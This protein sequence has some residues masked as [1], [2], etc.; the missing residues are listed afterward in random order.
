[1]SDHVAT[2]CSRLTAHATLSKEM[3]A[4]GFVPDAAVCGVVITDKQSVVATRHS[5]GRFG[6]V[7]DESPVPVTEPVVSGIGLSKYYDRME[8]IWLVTVSWSTDVAC[9]GRVDWR[10]HSSPGSWNAGAYESTFKTS[11]VAATTMRCTSGNS[12]DVLIKSL[13]VGGDEYDEAIF[14]IEINGDGD[15]EFEV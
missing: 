9:K 5:A 15:P 7:V 11:H 3:T 12:Y 4:A 8:R 13:V 14:T 6:A 10:V 2:I 1:V